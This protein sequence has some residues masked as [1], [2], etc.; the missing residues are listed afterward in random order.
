MSGENQNNVVK[1]NTQPFNK[2]GNN[3]VVSKPSSQNTNK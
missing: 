1:P 2:Q 3:P